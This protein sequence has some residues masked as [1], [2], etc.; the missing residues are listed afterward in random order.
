MDRSIINRD[1][2]FIFLK[3]LDL[4]YFSS[5]ISKNIISNSQELNLTQ[6]SQTKMQISSFYSNTEISSTGG[7]ENYLN[8]RY[9]LEL[10]STF[11]IFA[12]GIYLT[13]I[14][15]MTKDLEQ[16]SRKINKKSLNFKKRLS[17]LMTGYF[18]YQLFLIS[19]LGQYYLNSVDLFLY[20]FLQMFEILISL[21]T[22]FVI[23][24]LSK[25]LLEIP[26]RNF[27]SIFWILIFFKIL[28][29][30]YFELI[31]KIFFR[32]VTFS[33]IGLMCSGSLAYMFFRFPRD[34]LYPSN[35]EVYYELQFLPML[36][37]TSYNPL[38]TKEEKRLTTKMTT[39]PSFKKFKP[40]TPI[41]NIKENRQSIRTT[42]VRSF[43][44]DISLDEISNDQPELLPH[45]PKIEIFIKGDYKYFQSQTDDFSPMRRGLDRGEFYQNFFFQIVVKIK[46]KNILH[47]VKRS[48][49]DFLNLELDI[50]NE[51]AFEKYC[52]KLT[53]RLPHL[54][55]P[56]NTQSVDFFKNYKINFE[57]FLKNIVNEP[58][59][60]I[61]DVLEFLEIEDD[62]LKF[63]YDLA[64]KK[65]LNI[66]RLIDDTNLNPF[67]T[68][69]NEQHFGGYGGYG[70]HGGGGKSY[71]D[72]DD[73]QHQQE[74]DDLLRESISRI[75][76]T[77][78]DFSKMNSK[79][80]TSKQLP[81]QGQAWQ[82][83]N[84]HNLNLNK[85]RRGSQNSQNSQNFQNAISNLN[86]QNFSSPKSNHI[87]EAIFNLNLI[88]Q[89][90]NAVKFTVLEIKRDFISSSNLVVIRISQSVM[91]R[92][93]EKKL[94]EVIE[95]VSE[96]SSIN[97][98]NENI[99]NLLKM[100]YI[101]GL[102]EKTEKIEKN[103]K[104]EYNTNNNLNIIDPLSTTTTQDIS[105]FNI[106]KFYALLENVLQNSFDN[107]KL[108]SSSHIV[109]DF[110]CEFVDE[111]RTIS[112]C[113]SFFGNAPNAPIGVNAPNGPYCPMNQ[114]E[115]A[116]NTANQGNSNMN[117]NLN[118]IYNNM[119]FSKSNQIFA[120]ASP[121]LFQSGNNNASNNPLASLKPTINPKAKKRGSEFYQS[122]V[123]EDKIK[124][125]SVNITDS[126]FLTLEFKP[127]VFYVTQITLHIK[128]GKN[129]I[130]NK[131]FKYKELNEYI[132]QMALRLRI[133]G[134][135]YKNST[136]SK[137]SNFNQDS[138]LFTGIKNTDDKIKYRKFELQKNLEEIF[139]VLDINENKEWAEIFDRDWKYQ[140]LKMKKNQRENS[141]HKPSFIFKHRTDSK[142]SFFNL[143]IRD[144]IL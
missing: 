103:E 105:P 109:S 52:R 26:Y 22:P 61:D 78:D 91:F 122:L 45:Y 100:Y 135:L 55:L 53:E 43:Q 99:K 117:S 87:N 123:L 102:N 111:S 65:N 12:Y 80:T 92:I 112:R 17:V 16:S 138:S 132:N 25:K 90:S 71:H 144:S 30:I 23:R 85:Y 19:Y 121:N 115:Y 49:R 57:I 28:L 10:L 29:E 116:N 33:L 86:L 73:E 8:S 35:N 107:L 58:C 108:Y 34:D 84:D 20:L 95:M 94:S 113:E 130:I 64:R 77:N 59:Y 76:N 42:H 101:S 79:R 40:L 139:K 31:D 39:N 6:I 3:T 62:Q 36:T 129:E 93:V 127:H 143:N 66:S 104:M 37:Q 89:K 96:L 118:N 68:N 13:Y 9:Y 82:S 69:R 54:K 126:I 38:M 141:S 83:K 75:K 140:I 47:L 114:N 125:V 1:D 24:E 4:E 46:D 98:N 2:Q 60:I 67:P 27:F 41:N 70:G 74:I 110:F 133:T 119:T 5:N 32:T 88:K 81:M 44:N 131:K 11:P 97:K 15:H 134:K 51:F 21:L 106:T 50:K 48:I 56:K 142:D 14:I 7:S 128:D 137:N 18:F 63:S 120:S 136:G 72:Y 124:F